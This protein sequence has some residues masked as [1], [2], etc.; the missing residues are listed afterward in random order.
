MTFEPGQKKLEVSIVIL[1]DNAPEDT[2]KF[3]VSLTKPTGG[4]DIGPQNTIAVNILSNDNAHGI[5][6]I[7][8]VSVITNSGYH[9]FY[10]H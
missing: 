4:A 1:Q 8:D 10:V 2:E 5:I 7:A 3:F 9:I 6:E